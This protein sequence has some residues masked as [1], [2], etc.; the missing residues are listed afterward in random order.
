VDELGHVSQEDETLEGQPQLQEPVDTIAW[1]P[2]PVLAAVFGKHA[3]T[4]YW[5]CRKWAGNDPEAMRLAVSAACLWACDQTIR[6][7]INLD[8]K[9]GNYIR[10]GLERALPAAKRADSLDDWKR[11][12][13]GKKRT[14]VRRGRQLLSPVDDGEELAAPELADPSRARYDPDYRRS[15]IVA[16]TPELIVDNTP[17]PGTEQ[18]IQL[19]AASLLD[20]YVHGKVDT[21][22]RRAVIYV[23]V[24]NMSL[25][26]AA[27]RLTA[28]GHPISH[29]G[30]RL[31]IDRLVTRLNGLVPADP[32]RPGLRTCQGGFGGRIPI[33]QRNWFLDGL[34]IRPWAGNGPST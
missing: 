3:E 5:E 20:R 27:A 15:M 31:K 25:R 34:L 18:E 6:L 21:A 7:H 24:D 11:A 12:G 33:W 8:R 22:T 16:T 32:E 17:P 19:L 1:N 13:K 30:L 14:W 4:A 29:E 28:E 10:T 2:R 23:L 26:E 9:P